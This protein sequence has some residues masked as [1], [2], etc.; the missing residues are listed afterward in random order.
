MISESDKSLELIVAIFKIKLLCL[1]GFMPVI[2]KCVCC[3]EKEKLGYF[4]F[5]DSG[6]KCSSCALQDNGALKMSN[7]TM[8][9]IRYIVM[10]P[11][12]KL[13]SFNLSEENIKELEII[14]K[15]YLNDKLDKDY[16]LEDFF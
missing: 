5:R 7:S 12:K 14:S 6:F 15:I 11:P 13:F 9:A 4:S 2:D 3:G 1:L 8:T 16:K 10:A